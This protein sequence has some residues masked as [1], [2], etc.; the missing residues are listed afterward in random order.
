MTRADRRRKTRTA[1]VHAD[2]RVARRRISPV[3]ATRRRRPAAPVAS[4]LQGDR[5]GSAPTSRRRL[6]RACPGPRLTGP[7]RDRSR[8]QGTTLA[9]PRA[10]LG[11]QVCPGPE[12]PMWSR[13]RRAFTETAVLP[14][15]PPLS[16]AR[17][18]HAPATPPTAPP[19]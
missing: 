15:L 6:I 8:A 18:R 4:V 7:S 1:R 14:A 17:P 2:V 19:A 13:G 9:G 11:L 3:A 12:D 5:L 10:T 16:Y